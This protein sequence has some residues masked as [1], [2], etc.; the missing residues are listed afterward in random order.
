MTGGRSVG[1]GAQ[2]RYHPYLFLSL[3]ARVLTNTQPGSLEE[4]RKWCIPFIPLRQNWLNGA[5][6]KSAQLCVGTG[7]SP[8]CVATNCTSFT[9]ALVRI[10]LTLSSRQSTL[11]RRN[12]CF[13]RR[14]KH[15]SGANLVWPTITHY[16][17]QFFFV[18]LHLFCI[19]SLVLLLKEWPIL[20]W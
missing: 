16:F 19:D 18:K 9:S 8:D 5:L 7:T 20:Y 11:E 3:V 15:Q 2:L 12:L 6:K 4:K 10:T 17:F 1:R 14:P 13:F